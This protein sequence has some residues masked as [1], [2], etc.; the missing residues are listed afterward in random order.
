MRPVSIELDRMTA[1]QVIA[2]NSPLWDFMEHAYKLGFHTILLPEFYGGQG[3][4]PLQTHLIFEEFG[5]ASFGLSVFL[6]VACFPFYCACMTADDELVDAFVKPF[7]ECR[8]GSIRGCWAITEPD[9][10][11][12][13]IAVGEECFTSPQMVGSVQARLDGNEWVINGQKSS[14]VSGGTVATHALLHCQVDS[15]KGFA[16]NG[17]CIVPLDLN[18]VSR[19]APLEKI[20]QRDLNQGEIFFDE[21]RI[22]K[23]WMIVQPDFYVPMLDIILA[24][25]NLCMA[26]W[27]TGL[28]RAAMEEAITYSRDR[29]QGGKRLIEH[30][31]MKQ[32]IFQ[33]FGRVETSRAVSRSAMELNFNMSPPIC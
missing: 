32:R 14:W 15:S 4:T 25:A 17:I 21:V 29:V 12:D 30:Y 28:A 7:C 5:W 31:S 16:G 10:G 13:V 3:M 1:D 20:G 22:P 2:E 18:G 33:L 19:G 8:D 9:H 23:G 24:S 11:S 6:I 26:S 27:A